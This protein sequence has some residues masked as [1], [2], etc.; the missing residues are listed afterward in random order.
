MRTMQI[1]QSKM[2]KLMP[3]LMEEM[4]KNMPQGMSEMMKQGEAPVPAPA[5]ADE[6]E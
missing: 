5:A 6:S 3:R 1:S 2:A 4:T